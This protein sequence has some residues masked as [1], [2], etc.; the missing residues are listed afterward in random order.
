V[1]AD[2]RLDYVRSLFVSED[3]LAPAEVE[4]WYAEVL[5]QGRAA[6]E[7]AADQIIGFDLIRAA[8]VRYLG[9]GFQ[10]T[11]GFGRLDELAEAFRSKY[12]FL[13]GT[14]DEHARLE[15]VALHATVVGRRRRAPRAAPRAATVPSAARTREIWL[16]G[17]MRTVPVHGRQA[18][19]SGWRGRG[20]FVVEQPDTTCLVTASWRAEVHPTG[21]LLLSKDGSN[22]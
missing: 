3:A 1:L 21:T 16:D 4:R 2:F 13:Y 19:P 12:E 17:G 9:Q 10:V 6:L 5:R 20:P 14:R 15:V 11:V 8:E 18:L 7:N 22:G